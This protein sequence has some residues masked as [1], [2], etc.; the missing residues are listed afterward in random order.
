[1]YRLGT[2]YGFIYEDEY[3]APLAPMIKWTLER[4]TEENSIV[5]SGTSYEWGYRKD[6]TITGT[7]GPLEDG[8]MQ[9]DLE[10]DYSS[11]WSSISMTGHFDVGENSLRGTMTMSD[12]TSGEFV[13]K[14]DPDLIRFYPAPSSIDAEERWKFATSVILDRIRRQSWSSSYVRKRIQDGK[15]YMELAIRDSYYGRDL[16]DDETEEYGDLLSSLYESDARFYASLINIKLSEVPI[17]CVD[18]QL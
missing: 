17:Q 18:V 16:D 12:G 3:D 9:I 6:Y 11:G 15:R 7:T 10:I 5:A 1:M 14:R 13:F 4:G 8:K 2:Y